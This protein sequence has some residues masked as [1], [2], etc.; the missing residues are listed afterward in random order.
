[1]LFVLYTRTL[2][3]NNQLEQLKKETITE[4]I[5]QFYHKNVYICENVLFYTRKPSGLLPL[6]VPLNCASSF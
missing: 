6:T 2:S 1:M 5:L 4:L 3:E